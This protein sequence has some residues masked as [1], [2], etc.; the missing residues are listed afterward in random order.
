M[1]SKKNRR[2]TAPEPVAPAPSKSTP[3]LLIASVVAAVAGIGIFMAVSSVSGPS[4][5]ATEPTAQALATTT[6]ST[7]PAVPAG[8]PG[9]A[10]TA[11]VTQPVAEGPNDL[12][13]PPLPYLPQAAA[14]PPELIREAYVFAAQNPHVLNYVPCYCGCGQT[15]GHVGN[16]DCFVGSRA[17]NGAVLTWDTHGMT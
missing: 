9:P 8:E 1:A 7:S 12:P 15:D 16:T 6:P 5:A 17:P 11:A 14:G 2:R 3:W 10:A 13:I 4:V